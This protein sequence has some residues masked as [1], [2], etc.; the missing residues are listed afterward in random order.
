MKRIDEPAPTPWPEV[1]KVLVKYYGTVSEVGRA[2][3]RQSGR[4]VSGV[5][6]HM[7]DS[8]WKPHYEPPHSVGAALLVMINDRCLGDEVTVS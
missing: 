5:I 8:R 2:T 1:I 7:A 4:D 6:R 3:S